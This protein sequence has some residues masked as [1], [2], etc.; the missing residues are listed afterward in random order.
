M[1]L[2]AAFLGLLG[3]VALTCAVL[4][5]QAGYYGLPV[6]RALVIGVS[7]L[8]LSGLFVWIVGASGFAGSE[9][10]GITP[11]TVTAVTPTATAATP[12]ATSASN[13]KASSAHTWTPTGSMIM[14]QDIGRYSTATLLPNG[15]VLVTGGYGPS[16]LPGSSDLSRAELYNP[17]TGMWTATAS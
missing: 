8:L 2:V 1:F 15:Q 7:S 17:S 14:A 11:S 13:V 5:A 4:A 9:G 16:S 10:S 6:A 3:S 12:T